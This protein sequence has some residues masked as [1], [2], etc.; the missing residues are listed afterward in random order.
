MQ[1]SVVVSQLSDENGLLMNFVDNPMLIVDSS[2]PIPSEC[3]FERFRLTDSFER[4]P[5]NILNKSVYSLKQFLVG[6]LP[7]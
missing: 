5:R 1:F 6:F 4:L 3:M 2:R 7:V